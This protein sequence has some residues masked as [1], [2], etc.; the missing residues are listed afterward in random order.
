MEK[1]MGTV[2][3]VRPHRE[4]PPPPAGELAL[5]APPEPEKV[6]PGGV[7]C[8]KLRIACVQFVCFSIWDSVLSSVHS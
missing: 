5:Q 7:N 2:E 4:L 3:V 6:V 8:G 1:L